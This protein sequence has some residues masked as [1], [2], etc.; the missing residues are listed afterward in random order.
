[1]WDLHAEKT[2]SD[3]FEPSGLLSKLLR[4]FPNLRFEPLSAGILI[5]K[6]VL[7]KLL[8]IFDTED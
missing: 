5:K 3:Q 6:R 1:M 7:R 4:F 2:P 8:P